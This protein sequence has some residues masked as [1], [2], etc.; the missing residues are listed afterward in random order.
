MLTG[1]VATDR[2]VTATWLVGGALLHDLVLVPVVAVAG[3][4]VT[5]AVPAR[6]A[7]WCAAG[8]SSAGW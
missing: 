3:G 2:P 8:C 4:L 5:R 1:G 7:R 6:S